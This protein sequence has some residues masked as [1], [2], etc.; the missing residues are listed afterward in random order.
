MGGELTDGA[1]DL[2]G[3]VGAA[4][5]VD[6]GTDANEVQFGEGGSLAEVGGEPQA[7]ALGVAGEQL[8]KPDLEDGALARVELVDL[9]LIDIHADDLVAQFSHRRRVR[10]AEVATADY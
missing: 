3:V 4:V 2:S 1:V 6:G 7:P 10:D 5:G 9:G 8:G